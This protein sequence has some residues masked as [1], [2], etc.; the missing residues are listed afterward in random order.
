MSRF[1]FASRALVA[2]CALLCAT[3]AHA[4]ITAWIPIE[5]RE[6]AI[7]FDAAA[8][9][10]PVKALFATGANQHQTSKAFAELLGL[11][12]NGK[13]YE[14]RSIGGFEYDVR[15]VA[16]LPVKLFGVDFELHDVPAYEGG[17]DLVIGAGFLRSF[18][19]QI[20]YPNN[21]MRLLTHDA[22][23]MKK[24]GNVRLRY[25]A[26]FALP[27][28]EVEFPG[29]EKRWMQLDTAHTTPT[30]VRR[31]IAEDSGWLEK[32]T[33]RTGGEM[34]LLVLPSLKIGPFELEDVPIEV[35]APGVAANVGGFDRRGN[36]AQD[37]RQKKGEQASGI[38]GYELL[39]HF[40][41]TLDYDRQ[42]LHIAAPTEE[43][44]EPTQ[45]SATAES[46]VTAEQSATDSEEQ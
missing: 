39:R 33:K 18:I 19:V 35:P 20:D 11:D 7:Y 21:R 26:E 6:G 1:E 44:E 8:S 37:S 28:V 9:G 5:I 14:S 3:A 16:R 4:A 40:V 30:L 36:A 23:D 24:L 31:I 46:A 41:L 15:S 34:E 27:V 43:P 10:K 45:A 22:V 2:A 42:A 25:D 12:L 38:L 32:Y 17:G 13:R 29:G